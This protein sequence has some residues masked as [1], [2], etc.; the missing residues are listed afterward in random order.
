[1]LLRNNRFLYNVSDHASQTKLRT[2]I[3]IR[4]T[5]W[6]VKVALNI[7]RNRVRSYINEYEIG[8]TNLW[9]FL[10]FDRLKIT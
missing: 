1:M 4:G 5:L 10:H 2:A 6:T 7:D 3:Q 9:I 8:N